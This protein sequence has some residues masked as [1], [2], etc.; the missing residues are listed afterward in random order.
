MKYHVRQFVL[1]PNDADRRIDR[2]LR[3]LLPEMPLSAIYR[4]FRE[5]A[6]ILS[7]VKVKGAAKTRAGD[8]LEVRMASR[9]VDTTAS[10]PCVPGAGDEKAQAAE[11]IRFAGMIL[12]ETPDLALVNKPRGVL[13]H[14]PGGIDEA[15]R[16]YFAALITS[17][18]AFSPAPLH[19]LD[20]N[21]S[22][23]LAV[24]AS[25]A[26]AA[27]FSE[28]LRSGLVEKTYL[29]L[30]SGEMARAETWHDTLRRDSGT[31]TS[32]VGD[33]G[34]CAVTHARPVFRRDGLTL[35]SIRLDTG[36]THQI[37]VQAAAHG[38]PL[39]GDAKY[40]GLPMR[41][42]YILHCAA[43]GI[44]AGV[45]GPAPVCI[46]APLPDRARTVLSGL[47]GK[48]ILRVL[49]TMLADP[50]SGCQKAG[51]PA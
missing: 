21:T 47:F 11:S 5:K 28:A 23:A 36:R 51:H 27:K 16:A 38:H 2:I 13:T 31:G 17:S 37:R 1:G 7:G 32:F 20:R 44:P 33:G 39:A 34:K 48:E 9:D 41:G 45:A 22:G 14:G 19:R 25:S 40:G 29:A 42:G 3:K 12:L 18:L 49:D 8:I 46:V 6:V 30:L 43:L 50:A 4:L 24:S 26:G 15:A 35:A 10:N